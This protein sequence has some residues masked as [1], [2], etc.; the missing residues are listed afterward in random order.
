MIRLIVEYFP[1]IPGGLFCF[2]SPVL[3]EQRE[4]NT[5]FLYFQTLY[6]LSNILSFSSPSVTHGIYVET[7]QSECLVLLSKVIS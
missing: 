3:W 2:Q 7:L 4:P 5:E 1:K 6:L